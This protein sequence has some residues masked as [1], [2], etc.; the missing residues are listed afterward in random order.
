VT[1]SERYN[2][3]FIKPFVSIP[4]PKASGLS[5]EQ[6]L[7]FMHHMEPRTSGWERVITRDIY[8][9]CRHCKA[10]CGYVRIPANLTSYRDMRLQSESERDMKT[11]EFHCEACGTFTRVAYQDPIALM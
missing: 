1:N 9:R 7:D 3:E 6:C 2:I 4:G 8:G 10:H 11:V 5:L